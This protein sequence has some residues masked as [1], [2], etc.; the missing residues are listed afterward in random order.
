MPRRVNLAIHKMVVYVSKLSEVWVESIQLVTD[1]VEHLAQI[2]NPFK[3]AFVAESED[4]S[5][6]NS[7][8]GCKDWLVCENVRSAVNSL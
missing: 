4:S 5:I 8:D 2:G 3:T 6:W 7:L 1:L